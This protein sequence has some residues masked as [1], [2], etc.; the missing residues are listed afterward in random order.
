MKNKIKDTLGSS[1]FIIVILLIVS[2]FTLMPIINMLILGGI[3]A[4]GLIPVAKKF[5]TKV[6]Y[7]SIAIILSIIIIIIP[8]IIIF[9]Y[10]ISVTIDLSYSFINNNQDILSSFSLNQ[11]IDTINSYIPSQ[12]Q[13]STTYITSTIMEVINDIL[14]LVFGYFVDFIQTLPFVMLQIFVLIFSIFYFTRD[15]HK[16][17]KYVYSFIPK[18]KHEFFVN[19]IK[20][21]KIVLKSIFYGHF[22][23]GFC[24]RFNSSHRLFY[25]RVSI[26]NIFRNF[27]RS[28]SINTCNWTMA[29]IYNSIY[30]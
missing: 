15:G 17:K 19:M 10:T 22:F 18:E 12:M 27:N 16:I 6:K 7:S 20:E 5:Q 24:N 1:L 28:L 30:I 3:I 9:A 21:V 8:L 29:H 25:F 13:S 23:N 26:C 11:S 14:K 4:Y 2:L